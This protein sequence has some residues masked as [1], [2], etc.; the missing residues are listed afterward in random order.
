MRAKK[1]DTNHAEIVSH[2]RAIGW[3]IHDSSAVGRGFPD[4]V[5]AHVRT[6]QMALVE[7]KHGKGDLNPLQ[8]KFRDDWPG[9][10]FVVRSPDD[11]ERQLTLWL[12]SLAR[13]K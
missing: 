1:V 5:C 11:A 7:V 13:L 3:R 2:L 6:R 12:L 9:P 8:R 4:L 10:I